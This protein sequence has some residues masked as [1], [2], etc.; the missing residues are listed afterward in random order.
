MTYS[1]GRAVPTTLEGI[2]QDLSR[3]GAGVWPLDLKSQPADIRALLA[4]CHL[5]EAESKRVKDHFLFPMDRLL[6]IIANAGRSPQIPGGG[7]LSTFVTNHGY[8]YPQLYQVEDGI[9]Y[10]RFDR[11]HVNIAP[12]GEGVDEV[13][14]MLSGS[15]FVIHQRLDDGETLTLKLSCPNTGQGWLGTYSGVRPHIGSVSSAAVGSKFLVQVIGAPKWN[16]QYVDAAG[17]PIP[18]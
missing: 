8:G 17:N 5:D 15:G 10:S 18:E 9:D 7:A 12:K 11:F 13:F 2:N 16:L 1:D 6:E 4:K 3:I 14:Q